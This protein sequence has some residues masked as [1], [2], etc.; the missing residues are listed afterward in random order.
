MPTL[1]SPAIGLANTVRHAETLLDFLVDNGP[2]TAAE[3][4]SALDWPKGR[5]DSAVR[6]AREELCPTLDLAIPHPTPVDGWR[7]QVTGDWAPIEAGAAHALGMVETRLASIL[8]DVRSVAPNLERGTRAWRRAQ[9]L[10]KHL[11]HITTTL[12]EI[13]NG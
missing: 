7:Y 9:F 8:R 11:S 6:H 13:N 2:A 3:I 1:T 4:C 5:F 10:E 12:D